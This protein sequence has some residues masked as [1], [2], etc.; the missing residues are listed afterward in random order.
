[1]RT[2]FL[3]ILCLIL[4]SCTFGYLT[5]IDNQDSSAPTAKDCGECHVDQYGEWQQTRHAQAFTSVEFKQQSAYYQDSDCLFCHVPGD[6]LNPER[7]PRQYNREEGITCVSCHL[8]DKAMQGPHESGGLISPHAVARNPMLDSKADSAQL[9]G[10][11]HHE[12]YE[13]WL[14]QQE[15]T[16]NQYPTCLGCHGAPVKRSHTRGTNLFS[17]LLVSFEPQHE[18][19]SHLLMLPGQR[20]PEAAPEVHLTQNQPEQIFFTLTNTLPHDL[21]TG[22]F[23]EKYIM[24]TARRIKDQTIL[25]T[26]TMSLLSVLPPGQSVRLSLSLPPGTPGHTLQIDLKRLHRSTNTATLIRSYP[27]PEDDHAQTP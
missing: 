11:C 7:E 25:A 22:S 19:Q 26:N 17:R 15:I 6:V 10:T 18:V 20:N 13:Q 3:S 1:M 12:T 9:C 14:D 21:P 4:S 27:F 5:E 24:V 16:N 8:H 2:L 23:G